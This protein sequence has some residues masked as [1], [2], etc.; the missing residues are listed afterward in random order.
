[1]KGQI[2]LWPGVRSNLAEIEEILTGVREETKGG[3]EMQPLA[4]EAKQTLFYALHSSKVSDALREEIYHVLIQSNL[5][6][7]WNWLSRHGFSRTSGYSDEELEDFFQEG[8]PG[9]IKAVR[10]YDPQVSKFG[11]FCDLCIGNAVWTARRRQGDIMTLNQQARDELRAYQAAY[12]KLMIQMGRAR[13]PEDALR[14][15]LEWDGEKLKRIE[16]LSRSRKTVHSSDE[17]PGADLVDPATPLELSDLPFRVSLA[18]QSLPPAQRVTL[19][20]RMGLGTL[21]GRSCSLKE[22][23]KRLGRTK[24]AVQISE[25]GAVQKIQKWLEEQ[26]GPVQPPAETDHADVF[27]AEI[28]GVSPYHRLFGPL[29]SLGRRRLERIWTALSYDPQPEGKDRKS[30][31]EERLRERS[32][33]DE[34]LLVGA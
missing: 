29:E 3:K 14:E 9:V 18:L 24:Q 28:M 20:M 32:R 17:R 5:R 13:P 7:V 22:I 2:A 8:V 15:E 16:P 33:W 21:D 31:M 26:S 34:G 4:D 27:L 11:Y 19:K 25:R 30:G 12:E 10:V 1:M 23:G 6:L